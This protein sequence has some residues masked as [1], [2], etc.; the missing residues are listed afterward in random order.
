VV[1]AEAHVDRPANARPTPAP[2]TL[3]IWVLSQALNVRRH[4]D[5][6]RPFRYAEFGDPATGPSL[7]H[8]RAVNDL[9]VRLRGPLHRITG[10]LD[11]A[12]RIAVRR[13]TDGRMAEVLR[14][15]T[16]AQDWVRATERVWDFYLELFGQRQSTF[17]D[18]LVACDRIALDCYQHAYLGI[19]VP[20]SIPSPAPFVYMRTGFSPATYRR[21]IRLRKLGSQLNPFPLIQLPYHRLTNPWT[22]GAVLHEVS[23]NL[24]N[25]LGLARAVPERIARRLLAEGLPRSVVLTWT[26]WNREIFADLSGTLL[27][28]PSVVGSLFDVI[29]RQREQT[30][31][32]SPGGAH[33][34][35]YLRA[36]LST[37]LLNRMGFVEDAKRYE[38][39]WRILYPDR[40]GLDIPEPLLRTAEVAVPIVVEAICFTRYP[41]LGNRSLAGVL[42]FAAKEQAMVDE[43]A[44]RLARGTDPGIVPERFLIG[45]VRH[46][47]ERRLAPPERLMR[48]FY[49]ELGRRSR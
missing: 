14:L 24:H 43:A 8:V 33:P 29:G 23:H 36:F 31:R 15:K 35:P 47:V 45:A 4:L 22:L 11:A 18:W 46:A 49:T 30:T 34:T 48:N 32:Y 20:R 16:T 1:V 21:G 5:A 40:S 10:K 17:A 41:S 39:G 7:G 44:A 12:A 3:P 2:S 6:L 19:G 9:L 26:R 13:P 38:R 28:G 27:G 25:D 42:R 37:D